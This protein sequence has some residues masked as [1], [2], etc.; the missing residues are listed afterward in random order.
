MSA[1]NTLITRGAVPGD[2]PDAAAAWHYGELL[3]EQRRLEDGRAVV[4]LPHLEIIEVSGPDR[5][6]WLTTI[7]S[8]DLSALA[9]GDSAELTVL[10]PQGRVEHWAQVIGTP[11]S[12]L[13]ILDTGA[14]AGLRGYLE[15]MTFANRIELTDR[16]DLRALGATCSLRGFIDGA[17]PVAEFEESWPEVAPG[18]V[19]YS[20]GPDL[21]EPWFIGLFEESALRTAVAEGRLKAEQMAG[22]AAAEAI[23]V[24]N[25][26][27]RFA[28]DVDDRS[29]PHELDLLRT[30]VHTA[31]GC[32]RGQETVAKVLNLGQPPRRLVLL[33][34]DG[35]Q[36]L[37]V[38]VGAEVKFGKKSVGTV[39]TSV[40]HAD[41]GPVGL[42]MVRRAVPLDQPLTVQFTVGEDEVAVDAAQE[43]IV[44]EREHAAR[45][46]TSSLTRR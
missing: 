3:R 28:R 38:P 2:G 21:V 34:F 40:V 13:M 7:T 16:D 26:R 9:D 1:L 12:V 35:S 6:T 37:L 18:G 5:L 24:L 4:D 14:R 25:H 27:P 32:Y 36:D 33:H 8:Q 30:A 10:S 39:T 42:A 29:I 45:P 17:E 19:A 23:R 44:R 11:D 15:L 41:A 22:L 46:T 20:T 31:K 43:P